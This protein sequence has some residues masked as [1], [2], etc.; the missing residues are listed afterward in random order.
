MALLQ[1]VNSLR[2]SLL[3]L[4]IMG[5]LSKLIPHSEKRVQSLYSKVIDQQSEILDKTPHS[6]FDKIILSCSRKDIFG[7][8]VLYYLTCTK[9]GKLLNCEVIQRL[10]D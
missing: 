4:Y 2:T 10:I 6:D 3:T 9:P 8:D 1:N 5:R 7:N